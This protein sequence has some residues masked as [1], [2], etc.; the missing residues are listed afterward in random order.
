MNYWVNL[1]TIRK[2]REGLIVG[3]VCSQRTIQS[4]C[5]LVIGVSCCIWLLGSLILSSYL[6]M[7][8]E[9]CCL[10]SR[11]LASACATADLYVCS[12]YISHCSPC[13]CSSTWYVC[14]QCSPC[15]CV[16]YA[17]V[18]AVLTFLAL[19]VLTMLSVLAMLP[20]LAILPVF[21]MLPALTT[22]LVFDMLLVV[23]M[24]AVLASMVPV[25]SCLLCVQYQ[26]FC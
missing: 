9:L 5:K 14:C 16:C 12:L 18:L 23:V 3:E 21:S 8:Q 4:V 22:L 11:F 25:F 17:V 26:L 13:C 24:L 10:S 15:C 7:P 6:I 20:V 2:I 1:A 19:S